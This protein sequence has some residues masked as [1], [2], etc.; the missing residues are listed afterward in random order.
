LFV[1]AGYNTN[2]NNTIG[3]PEN[4]L[5]KLD[6]AM[7]DCAVFTEPSLLAEPEGV[8]VAMACHTGNPKT[9]KIIALK[10][11]H[12]MNDCSYIGNFLNNT[13]A[14]QINHDYS[15]FSAP[16]FIRQNYRL[17]LSVT[18]FINP[19][20]IYKGC[21][22]FHIKSLESAM[23]YKEKPLYIPDKKVTFSGA[24]SGTGEQGSIFISRLTVS[25]AISFHIDKEE[26]KFK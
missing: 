25:P 9:G 17:Y 15:G 20:D 21:L 7:S 11:S 13:Q 10:C 1:G 18:P 4:Y 5:N 16:E 19:N 24:C 6:K 22:L 12:S 14:S 26:I 8:Y 2:N 23:L 3:K